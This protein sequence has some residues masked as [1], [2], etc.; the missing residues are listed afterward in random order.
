MI[1]LP[2]TVIFI[3]L[4]AFFSGIETGLISLRKPRVLNGVA[5]NDRRARILLFFME[6]PSLMLASTLLGTN[7]CVVC[8]SLTAKHAAIFW[9]FNGG[10]GMFITSLL[11]TFALL[12]AEIIPKDW[13]RQDPY[14]RCSLFAPILYSSYVLLYVPIRLLA[15]FTDRIVKLLTHGTTHH[16]SDLLLREDFRLLLRESEEG[17]IIDS[18]NANLLDN[19]VEFS[20]TS[21]REVM[22]AAPRVHTV[23]ATATVREAVAV[24]RRSGCSRLPA[25]AADGSWLGIFSLYDAIYQL[26]ETDWDTTAVRQTCRPL[27]PIPADA[28]LSQIIRCSRDKKSPLLAVADPARPGSFLGIVTPLDV[29]GYLFN[30]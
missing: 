18:D 1:Y 19:A 5:K 14:R 7:L 13:F 11:L 22:I 3:L 15:G 30:R 20:Q 27:V 4:Q 24:C 16:N 12:A 26:P 2:A 23:A 17:G 9:G 28:E 10:C 8:A 21:V 29:V 25:V 6:R